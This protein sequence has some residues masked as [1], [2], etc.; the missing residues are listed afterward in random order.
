MVNLGALHA[1]HADDVAPPVCAG[2]HPWAGQP[3]GWGFEYDGECVGLAAVGFP[4]DVGQAGS[5]VGGQLSAFGGALAQSV[6]AVA[7]QGVPQQEGGVAGAGAGD[8]GV[9]AGGVGHVSGPGAAAG[10][11]DHDHAAGERGAEKRVPGDRDTVR[12]IGKVEP[13]PLLRFEQSEGN[14]GQGGVGVYIPAADGEGVHD[15]VD[16]ADVVDGFGH[17]GA[18][19]GHDDGRGVPVR[20]EP[21]GQVVVVDLAVAVGA[22]DLG[23]NGEQVG[24]LGHAVVGGLGVVDD[25]VSEP[26]TGVVQRVQV[27]LAATGGD[28]A[29]AAPLRGAHQVGDQADDLAFEGLGVLGADAV[30]VGVADVVQWL[31]A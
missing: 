5:G 19:V 7:G 10:G 15:L 3:G 11:L 16:A 14:A 13:G 1:G 4:A 29:P 6:Q 25:G 21:F 26:G 24:G 22:D 23:G 30:V 2:E 20:G 18:D 28:I 12:T 8:G 17:G 27:G 9:G 31:P